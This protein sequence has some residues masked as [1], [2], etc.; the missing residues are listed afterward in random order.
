MSGSTNNGRVTVAQ[1][2][3]LVDDRFGKLD[4][5]IDKVVECYS[6]HE[7][8]IAVLQ[9]RLRNLYI[10]LGFLASVS[11]TSL[12]GWVIRIITGGF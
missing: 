12:A 10:V 7:T 2:Y 5:K 8:K 11:V 1:L 6:E 4:S 9:A 3:E